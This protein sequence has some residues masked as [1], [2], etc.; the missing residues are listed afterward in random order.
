MFSELKLQLVIMSSLFEDDPNPNPDPDPNPN[1]DPNPDPPAKGKKPQ[2]TDEQQAFVN[3]LLKQ[4]REKYQKSARDAIQ[5]LQTLKTRS[6]LNDEERQT[7]EARI[8]QLTSD[9]STKEENAKRERE[10]IEKKAKVD[11]DKALEEGTRWKALF[12]ESTIS[13]SITDAAVENQAY[14]PEQIAAILSPNTKLVEEIGEDNKPTGRFIAQVS[15]TVTKDGKTEKKIMTV[16]DAVKH[17]KETPKHQNLFKAEGS[18]GLG[19]PGSDATIP[20]L[21]KLGTD[22]EAYRKARKAGNI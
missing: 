2:L 5:E 13:R 10:K 22:P 6:A 16:A 14:A 3:N 12:T 18:G 9:S 15:M 21:Q 19:R 7:L 20:D 8:E 11:L 4:E 17:L 1:P